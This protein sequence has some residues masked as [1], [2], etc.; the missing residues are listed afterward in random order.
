MT[1]AEVGVFHDEDLH[2][3]KIL[4]IAVMK[5]RHEITSLVSGALR[6]GH[7]IRDNRFAAGIENMLLPFEFR[8]SMHEWPDA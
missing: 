2:A 5:K 1:P 4:K 6:K 3:H 7:R 8:S